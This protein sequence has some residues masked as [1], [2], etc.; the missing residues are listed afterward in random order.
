MDKN[1]VSRVYLGGLLILALSLFYY[2]ALKGEHYLR[3]AKNNYVRVV[4]LRSIRGSIFDRNSRVLAYDKAVFNI[5]VIP[6]QIEKKKNSLLKELAKFSD[7]DV[8]LIHRNYNKGLNNI[9]SPVDVILD[10]NK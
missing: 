9:F 10:I 8:N 7:Y 1:I 6:H 5:A 4:P 2:Q 3:R